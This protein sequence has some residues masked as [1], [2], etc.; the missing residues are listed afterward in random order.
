MNTKLEKQN[1]L[2]RSTDLNNIKSNG[3]YYVE[4]HHHGIANSPTTKIFSL[5]VSGVYFVNQLCLSENKIYSRHYDADQKIWHS[6]R[7]VQM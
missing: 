5:I 6:W 1:Y 4:S 7:T 2:N 3:F